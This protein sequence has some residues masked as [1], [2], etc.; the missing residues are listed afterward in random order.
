LTDKHPLGPG[1]S[2]GPG[3]NI[4]GDYVEGDSAYYYYFESK[5]VVAPSVNVKSDSAEKQQLRREKATSQIFT[6]KQ[7]LKE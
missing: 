1:W 2:I 5:K 7:T 6:F 3:W 4:L